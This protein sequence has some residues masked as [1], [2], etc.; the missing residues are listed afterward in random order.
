MMR[1][2]ASSMCKIHGF[3]FLNSI[4]T[5]TLTSDDKKA[6]LRIYFNHFKII[7]T[8]STEH[9]TPKPEKKSDK[10]T[11]LGISL[12]NTNKYKGKKKEPSQKEKL[13][14]KEEDKILS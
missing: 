7:I 2:S 5:K 3:A 13:S 12:I 1:E 8:K 9:K 4:N 11:G 10:K 6:L 14:K